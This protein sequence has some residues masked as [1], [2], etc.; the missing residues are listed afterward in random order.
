MIQQ[1]SLLAYKEAKQS[2]NKTQHAVMQALEEIQPASN[3]MLAKH[4]GWEINSV[5]PRVLELRTKKKVIE[6]YRG[7]DVTGRT[8]IF[9]KP[10]SAY[11]FMERDC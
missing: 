4:L 6:A 5:T 11:E 8:A 3:K 7:K 1:T 10:K 9:W 2:L